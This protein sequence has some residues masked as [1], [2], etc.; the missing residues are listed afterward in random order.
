MY[1]SS[2]VV[3]AESASSS[4]DQIAKNIETACKSFVK[5]FKLDQID[6]EKLNQSFQKIKGTSTKEELG[7]EDFKKVAAV[8][9]IESD[10]VAK[11]LF[12]ALDADKSG[13]VDVREFSAMMAAAGSGGGPTRLRVLFGLCD[14]DGSGGVSREELSKTLASLLTSVDK[15]MHGN[16]GSVAQAGTK[17]SPVQ[18]KEALV[19]A[20][21]GEIFAGVPPTGSVDFAR[22]QKWAEGGS[23]PS[24]ACLAVYDVFRGA[25][26][27]KTFLTETRYG[28]YAFLLA[29]FTKTASAGVR[30]LAFTSDVGEAFRPVVPVQLVNLTYA[31]AI[32]YCVAD[33]AYVGYHESKKQEPQVTRTVAE[34][35]AFQALASVILPFLIIHTQVHVFHKLLHARGGALAKFGPTVAGLALIPLLPKICDEPVE[36]A[37]EAAFDSAWPVAGPAHTKSH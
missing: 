13:S 25:M 35:T 5:D 31:I 3:H 21:I 11:S 6:P 24:R 10:E 30:Y 22:F 18:A 12:E 19:S 33:V 26:T 29:R 17:L 32:G 14:L 36:H 7:L 34:R 37:I 20:A 9:G 15:M 28:A 1:S 23:P 16:L 4:V 8:I 27:D 2:G